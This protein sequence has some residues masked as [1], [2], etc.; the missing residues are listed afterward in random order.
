M[1]TGPRDVEGIYSI[2]E[3]V[4][5]LRRLADALEKGKP[6]RIQV[7]GERIRVPRHAQFSIEHER[8]DE[9][10]EIELQLKWS[11]RD[12]A[13]RPLAQRRSRPKEVGPVHRF[14]LRGRSP[15][16]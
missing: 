3:A 9:E 12:D 1:A 8:D 11:L 14:D 13:R 15:R 4:A 7:A 6:F 16:G 5:K 2:P 10:E